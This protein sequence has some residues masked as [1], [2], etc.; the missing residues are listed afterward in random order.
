MVKFV[1]VVGKV[2]NCVIKNVY[3]LIGFFRFWVVV[4]MFVVVYGKVVF[5]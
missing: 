2:I 1:F 3:F 5:E 4:F